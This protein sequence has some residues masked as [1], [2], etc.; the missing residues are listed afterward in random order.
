[1]NQ[2]LHQPRQTETTTV[3]AD[4]ETWKTDW[5]GRTK[6]L[7]DV[8]ALHPVDLAAVVPAREPLDAEVEL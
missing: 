7:R 4:G 1:M 8:E 6:R 3:W 5:L 2:P